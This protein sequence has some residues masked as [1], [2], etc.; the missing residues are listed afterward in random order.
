M[1]DLKTSENVLLLSYV[2]LEV[3]RGGVG[4]NDWQLMWEVTDKKGNWIMGEM[5]ISNNE[6]CLVE[7]G[8][9]IEELGKANKKGKKTMMKESVGGENQYTKTSSLTWPAATH[10]Y[11]NKRTFLLPQDWFGTATWPPLPP[12]F[13]Q[14]NMAAETPC[15][16]TL[17]VRGSVST[18]WQLSVMPEGGGEELIIIQ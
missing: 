14:A 10:I 11:W 3:G 15:A 1:E 7:G 4:G 9:T 17:L 5:A 6:N 16:N 12:L 18:C 2:Y 8:K 13:W